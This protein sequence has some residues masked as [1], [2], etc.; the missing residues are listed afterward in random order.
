[1]PTAPPIGGLHVLESF[2]QDSIA[3]P[4]L[5]FSMSGDFWL[6]RIEHSE[7]IFGR[8]P[9]LPH[10][11]TGHSRREPV[12]SPMRMRA[13]GQRSEHPADQT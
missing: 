3:D 7:S 11:M 10:R 9:Y 12:A 8:A 5:T 13:P 4:T 6:F 1:M 2:G